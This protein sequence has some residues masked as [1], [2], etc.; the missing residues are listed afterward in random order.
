MT[1]TVGVPSTKS[2]P[3]GARGAHGSHR[4]HG[5]VR[6]AA[7]AVLVP[8]ASIVVVLL[9]WQLIAGGLHVNE[10]EL[11]VPSLIF[12]TMWH[13]RSLLSTYTLTTLQEIILGFALSIAV[14][15]P[16]GILIV[17]NRFFYR[18]FYPLVVASQMVP[19]V[20]VAPL[21]VVWVGTGLSSKVL[22]AFLISFFPVVVSTTLG[23]MAV[24][25]DQVKLFRSMGSSSW[26]TFRSLRV[27]VALPSI[28][29]GLKVAMSLSVVGAIVGEFVAANSGLGYYLLVANGQVDTPGVFAAL[30]V[31]A[32]MGVVLYYLVELAERLVVPSTLVNRD[33]GLGA[34]M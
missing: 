15:V 26:R 10:V 11:P 12:R 22:V 30:F 5:S 8:L 18:A 21:F 28:F 4:S 13:E 33:V 2:A 23:F 20:A 1:S 29:S 25:P 24:D 7:G 16:I 34:T 6:R 9:L 32:V 31:L 27:P 19:K 3:S 17:F 14:G